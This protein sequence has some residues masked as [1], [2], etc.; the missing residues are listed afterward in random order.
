MRYLRYRKYDVE[1]HLYERKIIQILPVVFERWK[2]SLA[3]V[4]LSYGFHGFDKHD[5]ELNLTC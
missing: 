4:S 5:R 3:T 1:S 2:I